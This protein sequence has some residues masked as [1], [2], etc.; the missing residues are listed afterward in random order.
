MTRLLITAA[1][2]YGDV[3]P[4]T[5]LGAGLRAAGY[6]VALASHRSFAPLVE[7]AGL[8]FRELPDSPA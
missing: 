2:S 5:G 7:A 8:R 4:Y 6:D 3:A 1:G